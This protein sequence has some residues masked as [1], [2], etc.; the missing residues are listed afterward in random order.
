MYDLICLIKIYSVANKTRMLQH[1]SLMGF[2][3]I[4]VFN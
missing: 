3:K 2:K 1:Y 4:C